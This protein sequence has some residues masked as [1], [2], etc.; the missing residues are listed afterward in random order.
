MQ[1]FF[2]LPFQKNIEVPEES[3]S[4]EYAR[5]FLASQGLGPMI[6]YQAGWAVTGST[7]VTTEYY[8]FYSVNAILNLGLAVCVILLYKLKR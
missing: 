4:E 2:I 8:G 5:S 6:F 3:A 7:G 1:C